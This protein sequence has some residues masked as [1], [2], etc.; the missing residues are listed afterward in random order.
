VLSSLH[1]AASAKDTHKILPS[2]RSID[3]PLFYFAK[4][5]ALITRL[6]AIAYLRELNFNHSS[7]DQSKIYSLSDYT[8]SNVLEQLL[9]SADNAKKKT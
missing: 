2:V 9:S 3:R 7:G 1:R 5:C 4:E 8:Y 6:A